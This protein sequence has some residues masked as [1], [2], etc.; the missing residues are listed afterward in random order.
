MCKCHVFACPQLQIV[1][2]ILA[3]QE[4]MRVEITPKR[5][6]CGEGGGG[7]NEQNIQSI[8]RLRR[9]SQGRQPFVIRDIQKHEIILIN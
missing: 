1:A 2:L 8:N 4:A 7:G 9:L 5:A 3:C 6:P